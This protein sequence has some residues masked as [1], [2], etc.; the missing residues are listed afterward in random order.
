[1]KLFKLA[2]SLALALSAVPFVASAQD[3]EESSAFS[4]S[5]DAVSDYVWRGV[6]QSDENPTLQ[7]GFTY[8]GEIGLYAGV[9]GSGVD[10]GSGAPDVEVD[11]FVGFN[12]DLSDS[13]NFDIMVNR[14]TYPG[15]SELNFNELLTTTT[16][17]DTYS[18]SVNYSDDFGGADTDAWYVGLGASWGLPN[19]YSLDVS[20]GRSLF[21]K[22]YSDDYTDW[23]VGVGKSWGLFSA[24]LAYVGTDGT[25]RDLYGNLADD[26]LVLSLS[27]GQ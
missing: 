10:F 13:V 14:Y 1:M 2:A 16:F 11:Y 18:L 3:A 27:I 6:S 12:K 24:K 21:E 4:W 19:D 8:T 15:A 23:S 25:G 22:D 20:V 5:V 7:A 17:A 9:W 26:R